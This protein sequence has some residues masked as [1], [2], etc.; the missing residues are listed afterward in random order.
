MVASP[1]NLAYG[2]PSL[3]QIASA[4]FGQNSMSSL[5]TRFMARMLT[6]INLLVMM[7]LQ[8]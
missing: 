8:Q 1:V 7:C 4:H 2:T 5:P 6:F 3:K